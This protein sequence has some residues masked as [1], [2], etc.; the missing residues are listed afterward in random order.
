MNMRLRILGL[1]GRFGTGELMTG[2][3]VENAAALPE[4]VSSLALILFLLLEGP[5]DPVVL[6]RLASLLISLLV[7]FVVVQ[8][9]RV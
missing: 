3:K 5:V 4:V 8:L 1:L 6:C 7:V 2:I 9:Y